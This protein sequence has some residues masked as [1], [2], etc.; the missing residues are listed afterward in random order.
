MARLPRQNVQANKKNPV[1][2]VL[3]EYCDGRSDETATCVSL[4]CFRDSVCI[5]GNNK[6]TTSPISF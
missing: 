1:H 6:I 2:P 3:L 4:S 5:P